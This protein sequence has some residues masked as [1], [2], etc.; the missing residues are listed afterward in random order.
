[1]SAASTPQIEFK[2]G[3]YLLSD[4]GSSNGTFLNSSRLTKNSPVKLQ[5][6]D[7]IRILPRQCFTARIVE[8]KM[9][10]MDEFKELR[11]RAQCLVTEKFDLSELLNE[12]SQPGFCR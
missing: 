12:E 8:D 1:V 6:W 5:N 11:S 4:L 10:I 3:N 2:K 7:K 9:E